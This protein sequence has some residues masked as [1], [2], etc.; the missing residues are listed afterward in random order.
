MQRP[1]TRREKETK[2]R[3]YRHNT[4]IAQF[5]CFYLHSFEFFVCEILN[6]RNGGEKEIWYY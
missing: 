6:D 3:S 2:D 1:K 4:P 5:V